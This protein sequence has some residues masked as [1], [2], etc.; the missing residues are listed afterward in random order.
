MNKNNTEL[1]SLSR[2]GK[3]EIVDGHNLY[4]KWLTTLFNL[5]ILLWTR[6]GICNLLMKKQ[7]KRIY[8]LC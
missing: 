8:S 6:I 7:A 3:K 4:N 1:D 2:E 5:I